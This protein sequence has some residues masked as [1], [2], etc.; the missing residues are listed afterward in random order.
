MKKIFISFILLLLLIPTVIAAKVVENL[1]LDLSNYKN[2]NDIQVPEI[3]LASTIKVS[4]PVSQDLGVAVIE[5]KTKEPQ[6]TA[7]IHNNQKAN[8]VISDSS[9]IKG[10]IDNILDNDHLT[11]TEFDL[12]KDDGHAY[13]V[14]DFSQEILSSNLV[15][16]LDKYVALPHNIEVK[17]YLDGAYFTVFAKSKI[18]SNYINFPETKSS[19]WRID[20]WHSQP[21]RLEEINIIDQS[22][23]DTITYDVVWLARPGETYTLYSDATTYEPLKTGESGNLLKDLDNIITAQIINTAA[24]PDYKDPDIDKDGIIDYV[25]NCVMVEN[26]DQKDIDKNGRGDACEDHDKDGIIDS[27]D[28]CPNHPNYAQKDEDGDN[29]GDACDGEESRLTERL[30]WLPSVAMGFAGL[31]VLMLIIIT[32]KSDKK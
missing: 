22:E 6:P 14:I 8:A 12:D 32:V 28:N 18:Y 25:D 3:K 4:L 27:K 29:I 5:N 30:T 2:T 23:K 17:A 10:S 1:P 20:F 31:I 13:I 26:S 21:L 19:K 24:N 9:E 11:K 15:L 16:Y 7:I